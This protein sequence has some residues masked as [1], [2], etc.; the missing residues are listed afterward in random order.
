MKQGYESST[1]TNTV[2]LVIFV[3]LNFRGLRKNIWF[4]GIRFRCYCIWIYINIIF[5][6]EYR[7]VDLLIPQKQRKVT[8][9]KLG[10]FA[11]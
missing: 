7:F 8:P 4:I 11:E 10:D 2:K 6:E 1:Y 9:T 3:G 5:R